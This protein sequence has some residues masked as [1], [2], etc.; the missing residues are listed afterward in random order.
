MALVLAASTLVPASAATSRVPLSLTGNPSLTQLAL[1]RWDVHVGL[2]HGSVRAMA[3][4]HGGTL[5]IGTLGGLVRFDGLALERVRLPAALHGDP[6]V[7]SLLV[8][9]GGTLWVGTEAGG[10]LHRRGA[11]WVRVP[12][13]DG[14]RPVR[15]LTL[16]LAPDGAV[17]VGTAGE[18]AAR[19][20][21]SSGTVTWVRPPTRLLDT[22]VTSIAFAGRETAYLGTRQGLVRV[23]AG[24]INQWRTR[25]GLPDA[26]ITALHTDADGTLWIGTPR[27]IAR[28]DR[29]GL[30]VLAHPQL[31]RHTV[32]A[33]ASNA[34]GLWIGTAGAGLLRYT[35]GTVSALTR[36]GGLT[37][38]Q[39]LSVLVDA[40]GEQVW[41]GTSSGLTLGTRAPLRSFGAEEGLRPE[42]LRLVAGSRDGAVYAGAETGEVHRFAD[43]FATTYTDA[44]RDGRLTGLA[45]DAA[46]TMWVATS[47]GVWRVAPTGL[48]RLA[49][50]PPGGQFTA[51]ERAGPA[52]VTGGP[53]VL[54]RL[55]GQRLTVLAEDPALGVVHDIAASDDGT[56][57]LGT[58][59]GAY[60]YASGELT[61][62]PL[63]PAT[64]DP[65]V[66]QVL[67]AREGVVW[68]ATRSG[69]WRYANGRMAALRADGG[70]PSSAVFSVLEDG[71][72]Q[73]WLTS[74]A[75]LLAVHSSDVHAVLDGRRAQVSPRTFD[76]ADGLKT[77]DASSEAQPVSWRAPGGDIYLAT[78]RGLV[79]AV[80]SSL[81]TPVAPTASVRRVETDSA[82]LPLGAELRLPPDVGR[83]TLTF[84][85]LPL[86]SARQI[87]FRYRLDGVDREWQHTRERSVSYSYVPAGPQRFHLAASVDRVHWSEPTVL[88]LTVAPR[89]WETP[90][91]LSLCLVALAGVLF[92]IHQRRLGH[93]RE[94]YLAVVNERLRIAREMHDTIAQSFAA[95]CMLLEAATQ[96]LE[97][98]AA[99]ARA[100]IDQSSDVARKALD[101]ARFFVWDL[102]QVTD[103]EEGAL[104]EQLQAAAH[105]LVGARG[106]VELTGAP[107]RLPPDVKLQVLAIGREALVNVRRHA[108]ASSVRVDLTYDERLLTLRLRD[109]GVGF[110]TMMSRPGGHF[111]LVGMAERARM[112]H[113]RLDIRSAPGEGT[114]VHLEV[115]LAR[116]VPSASDRAWPATP[117]VPSK[118][119][120]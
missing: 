82:T 19:V 78:M 5:W 120:L 6:R 96:R 73:L 110:D 39:V 53:G 118:E 12:L 103:H 90:W 107:R 23:A 112:M 10:L 14:R 117:T 42:R 84:G 43:G 94:R 55:D 2:P 26:S 74:P 85:V 59:R 108:H 58:S 98:D 15:I 57:W 89:V 37:D 102:R 106:V 88:A 109:D 66:L 95:I 69:L 4:D 30:H 41:V 76:T 9:Q 115:P 18:G 111:G 79:R 93:A 62:L 83:L 54:S 36:A 77:L 99:G 75:G 71:G 47:H 56:L 113:A 17:W 70:L 49:V 48:Q 7:T 33:L 1:R 104:H 64:P 60:R 45:E 40:P 11:G 86:T 72:G 92:T 16:A 87:L 97:S 63:P 80:P 51:L 27:G 31:A 8:D 81:Q 34:E 100:H 21:P 29:T 50:L 46:G 3:Q 24:T 101:Q 44:A 65:T 105:E 68:L 61:V 13:D 28:M 38:D 22:H 52:L 119:S 67:P 116:G 20:V 32:T 35:E 91:F 25:H 114:E